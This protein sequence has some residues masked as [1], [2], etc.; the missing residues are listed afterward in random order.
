MQ[1]AVWEAQA[2]VFLHSVMLVL[3]DFLCYSDYI[4]IKSVNGRTAGQPKNRKE[5]NSHG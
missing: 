4:E 2:S 3:C 5:E 1:I